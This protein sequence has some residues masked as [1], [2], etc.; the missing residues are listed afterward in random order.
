MHFTFNPNLS[1][2]HLSIHTIFLQFFKK[3]SF[4]FLNSL[5]LSNLFLASITSLRLNKFLKIQKSSYFS[6]LT[7]FSGILLILFL[8]SF[9][10]NIG[11]FITESEISISKIQ[12]NSHLTEK[13][14]QKTVDL[15][16][17]IS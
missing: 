10:A 3:R 17:L 14:M 2:L 9:H 12:I 15:G 4:Q 13:Y 11:Q 7:S 1:I 5:A 8:T 16:R 6:F